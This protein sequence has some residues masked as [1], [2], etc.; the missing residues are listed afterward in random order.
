MNSFFEALIIE[1]D[2]FFRQ[3]IGQAVAQV[4]NNCRIHYCESAADVKVITQNKSSRFDLILLDLGLPDAP[5]LDVLD[6]LHERFPSA[7]LMVISIA[8]DEELVLRAI[9]QGASGYIL[10]GD[11]H[12][13][14]AKA[15]EQILAGIHPISPILSGY[16]LKLAGKAIPRDK[17]AMA[18]LTKKERELLELFAKGY[19]YSTAA[20]AMGVALSTV[21]THTRNLYRKL[22]V[23]SSL[24]A[25]SKAKESGLL[26]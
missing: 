13:S 11:M 6:A 19:S 7:P 10:K 25:L 14:V 17:A 23:R 15:I 2:P 4:R 8:S 3:V 16:F 18:K 9:Q 21:Q 22:Q 20:A 26:S 1:D 5:G 12:L 24:Q